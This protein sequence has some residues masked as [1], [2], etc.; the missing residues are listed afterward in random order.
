M[1]RQ[2]DLCKEGLV[3][4]GP[5]FGLML[6]ALVYPQVLLRVFADI[7]LDGLVDAGGI[8]FF[9]AR[10]ESVQRRAELDFVFSAG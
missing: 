2:S 4:F 8:L 5:A 6:E 3:K 7:V 9:I 10:G 1:C